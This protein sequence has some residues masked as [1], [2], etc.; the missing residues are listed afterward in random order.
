MKARHRYIAYLLVVIIAAVA[1]FFI[2]RA[3]NGPPIRI[4]VLDLAGD[5]TGTAGAAATTSPGRAPLIDAIRLAVEEIN[6]RGGLLGRPVE[7]V[8]ADVPPGARALAGEAGRL[9]A[10]RGVSALFGCRSSACLNAIKDVVEDHDHLLFHPFQY[11]GMV[12]SPNIVHTGPLPNQQVIPGTRWGIDRFGRRLYLIGSDAAFPRTANRIVR[13]LAT[14]ADAT[15]L[16]ERYLAPAGAPDAALIDDLRRQQ[17][18]LIVSTLDGEGTRHFFRAV[19]DAGLSNIP[20]LSF[21]VSEIE[22]AAL[23]DDAFHPAHYAAWSYFQSLPGEAN[24][25]FVAAYKARFGADRV[26]ADAIEAAYVSVLI[27][28]QAVRQAGTAEPGIVNR[29]IGR[30]SV[31]GPSGVMAVDGATRYLWKPFRIGQ[32]GKDGQFIQLAASGESLR[33]TPFPTYRSVVDWQAVMR[34]QEAGNP[35]GAKP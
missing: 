29:G 16:G 12:E 28:A 7:L 6:A 2:D 26:T 24:R 21:S 17:P 8:V 19:R 14:A 11:E 33:P 34:P 15:I 5:L 3:R 9:I 1:I 23:R 10:G 32:A 20:V 35:P 13:D 22:L 25:R 31:T 30:Q 27:W 4:G 18:E